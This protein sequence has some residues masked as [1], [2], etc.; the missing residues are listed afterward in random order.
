MSADNERV[1]KT[2]IELH[3]RLEEASR[4]LGK[5]RRYGEPATKRALVNACRLRLRN[6]LTV[7]DNVESY[8]AETPKANFGTTTSDSSNGEQDGG[9]SSVALDREGLADGSESESGGATDPATE[10]AE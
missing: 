6:I 8:Y 4:T 5:V 10:N 2:V 9:P 1:N 3:K 7:L